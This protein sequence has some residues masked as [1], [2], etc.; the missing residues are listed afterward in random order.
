MAQWV[1]AGCKRNP[2]RACGTSDDGG[3]QDPCLAIGPATETDPEVLT[4]MRDA[5][6]LIDAALEA[7]V[8]LPSPPE[9]RA[10]YR[11]YRAGHAGEEA[12]KRAFRCV[13]WGLA[14]G[15]ADDFTRLLANAEVRASALELDELVAWAQAAAA[16]EQRTRAGAIATAALRFAE[17]APGREIRAALVAVPLR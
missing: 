8:A 1:A 6:E 17:A 2:L 5:D 10:W 7:A 15:R 9:F 3:W 4:T 11:A 14:N 13:W 12:V 16:Q